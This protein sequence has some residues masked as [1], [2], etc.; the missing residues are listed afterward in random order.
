M[1][2]TQKDVFLWCFKFETKCSTLKSFSYSTTFQKVY[3]YSYSVERLKQ[4]GACCSKQKLK[5]YVL[6]IN[7]LDINAKFMFQKFISSPVP[8]AE[9]IHQ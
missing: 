3:K 8:Y 9:E 4:N 2:K 7:V 6:D 1:F 5:R